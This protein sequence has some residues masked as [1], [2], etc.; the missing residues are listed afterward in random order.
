VRIGADRRRK[1]S[2]Q[3]RKRQ[4]GFS[5]QI[6]HT[7]PNSITGDRVESE[8]TKMA[9]PDSTPTRA[10]RGTKPV[11]QAF[12]SALNIIPEASR[13]AVAKAAQMMIRDE[14]KNRRDKGRAV[15]AKAKAKAKMSKMV[16]A[17]RPAKPAKVAPIEEPA[18]KRRARKAPTPAPE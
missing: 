14:L 18:V 2:W 3:S 6:H 11:I 12:F 1:Q 16:T 7:H 4:V 9:K 8:F 17:K 10:P 5:L 13:A 15:A